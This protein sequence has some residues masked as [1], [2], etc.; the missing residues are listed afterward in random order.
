MPSPPKGRFEEAIENY[1]KAIQINP[2]FAVALNNLGAAL[3]TEGRFD[4][5]I[6]NFRKAIQVNP[7]FVAAQNFFW[8]PPLPPRAG[9]GSDWPN[10]AR[11]SRFNPNYA[12]R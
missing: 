8:G 1:R 12:G 11:P 6:E 4:E 3:A 5:A 9:L 7:N 10:F 2:N